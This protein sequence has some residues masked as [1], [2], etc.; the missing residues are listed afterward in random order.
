MRAAYQYTIACAI[1]TGFIFG[2]PKPNDRPALV[3]VCEVLDNVNRYADTD[4]A[5]VGRMD[6]SIS[7]IDH[8]EFLSQDR[9]QHPLITH[10]HTFP[11]R[12][13]ILTDWEEGLPKPPGDSPGFKRARILAKLAE[14]RKT[15]RLGSHEEPQFDAK[16]KRHTAVVRSEWMLVYGRLVKT[17]GLDENCGV[18][19]CGGD[20]VPLV[21][22]A[23]EEEV[24][25]VAVDDSPSRK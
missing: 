15:T 4:V 6:R 3:T 24:Q 16:G 22:I 21:I 8:A 1:S 13:Q 23:R 10:G 7:V 5:I 19:G 18:R 14:V 12:I 2:Q 17:P 20:D 9:C 25:P 11:N